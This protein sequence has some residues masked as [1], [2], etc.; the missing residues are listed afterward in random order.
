MFSVRRHEKPRKEMPN[1]TVKS[2]GK[3]IKVRACEPLQAAAKRSAAQGYAIREL[4]SFD[5]A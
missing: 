4:A 1:F 2:R 5:T 3:I